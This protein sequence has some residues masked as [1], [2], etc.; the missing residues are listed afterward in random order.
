[1]TEP[2]GGIRGFDHVSLPMQNT[3]AMVA[4]YRSLGLSVAEQPY[5]VSVYVGDQMINLHR[6]EIWRQKGFS[7]RAPAA[8]PPCGDLCFV[9]GGSPESLR[10]RLDAAG[11]PVVEG[12][13]ERQGGR[14]A[15]ATSVYVRDPDGN[16]LEFLIYR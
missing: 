15:A 2:S 6:P 4:F 13:V 1:M 9:W 12:P 11:A 10:A 14:R 3:D 7:L 8:T 5:V 16:L